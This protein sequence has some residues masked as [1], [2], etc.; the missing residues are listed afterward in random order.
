MWSW[1]WNFGYYKRRRISWI[2][3]QLSG[4]R[5]VNIKLKIVRNLMFYRNYLPTTV[6]E[7]SKAWTLFARS[8]SRIVG[9]NATQGMDVSVRLFCVCVVLFVGR[10]LVTGWSPVEGVLPTVYRIEKLAAEAR[11]RAVTCSDQGLCRNSHWYRLQRLKWLNLQKDG[12]WAE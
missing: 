1:Q 12:K 11:Q 6:A 4:S 7:R 8:N 2:T 9:S 5:K 3:E 10:G